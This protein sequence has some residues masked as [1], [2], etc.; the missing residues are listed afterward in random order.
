MRVLLVD[1]EELARAEIRVLLE[2]EADVEIVGECSNAVEAIAAINRLQPDVLFLD[3]QMPR[4]SGIEMVSMID[5]G[6]MPRIVFLTA[7][8]EYALRAFDE[9]ATDYLLKPVQEARL[10]KTLARLRQPSA[11]ASSPPEEPLQPLRHIP[12]VGLNRVRLM[13]I[14]EI[15][16]I[17]SKTSGI[18]VVGTDGEEHFTELTLR[19]LEER[20]D[21]I[22]C[23]RQVMVNPDRIRD[24][25]FGDSGLATIH[26]IGGRAL[27][28]SRRFL[29]PLKERLGIS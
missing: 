14:E 19:T 25:A 3:V 15:E 16:A 5:P 1:D 20:T 24:I 22:R 29:G 26:T 10:A 27:P 9:N 7:Y 6:R 8:E 12:C 2:A 17:L 23:H 11:G 13:K 28:V 21:L 18:Y 4:I